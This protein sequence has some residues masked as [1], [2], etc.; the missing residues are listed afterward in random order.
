M[1]VDE[2]AL[3]ADQS[4]RARQAG[5][6]IGF[7]EPGLA[8]LNPIYIEDRNEAELVVGWLEDRVAPVKH[9][10][11]EQ[12]LRQN[13]LR[14]VTQKIETAGALCNRAAHR[15]GEAA[16]LDQRIRHQRQHDE[17]VIAV[18]R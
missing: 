9:D 17:A 16:R 18:N 6:G 2:Q 13:L 8:A 5:V 3:H 1:L 14:A 11:G 4:L 15:H 7:H 12:G 10:L